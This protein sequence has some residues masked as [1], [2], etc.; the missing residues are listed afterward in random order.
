MSVQALAIAATAVLGV[1]ML[2]ASAW[3]ILNPWIITRPLKVDGSGR[4]LPPGSF[5]WPFFGEMKE[6]LQCFKNDKPDQFVKV[7][8]DRYGKGGLYTTSMF[9]VPSIMATRPEVLKFVLKR[10]DLFGPGWP[11]LSK[12]MGPTAVVSVTG[13]FHRTLRRYLFDAVASPEGMAKALPRLD[14]AVRTV[15][16]EWADQG[17][18]N[19]RECTRKLTFNVI[20]TNFLSLKPSPELELIEKDYSGFML[21]IRALP[22]Y[23]PGTAHYTAVNCRRRLGARF[24]AL[25]NT[26]RVSNECHS[27][28]LQSLMEARDSAGMPLTDEQLKDNL[29]ALMLAGYESSAYTMMWTLILLAK[30]PQCLTKLREEHLH[31]KMRIGERQLTLEVIDE[32]LR[33]VNVAPMLFRTVLQDVDFSGYRFPKGWRVL[34]WLRAP[35]MDPEYFPQPEKFI[36]ERWDDKN[37][38]FE[39]FRPFGGGARTCVGNDFARLQ[40]SVFLHHVS[41]G[42]K[43][44]LLNPDAKVDHLPHPKPVD[45]GPMN[46]AVL[47]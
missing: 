4:K 14:E 1:V 31:I 2:A 19:I 29:V 35:H 40:V 41:V 6:F 42:Y 18:V 43:W 38:K 13:E 33:L 20:A 25:I 27:D 21:G 5:G 26:R 32:T 36:P 22:I 8:E 24:Q 44:A 11:S 30:H 15:L 28:F 34:P 23:L 47:V 7:R 16:K 37:V 17:N 46:F 45:G 9:G 12:I 3:R 10:D 39:A